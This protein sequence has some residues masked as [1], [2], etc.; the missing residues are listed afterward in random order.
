MT[1]S[2]TDSEYNENLRAE[3][4]AYE[5]S[6][7]DVM[8]AEYLKR[9][10]FVESALEDFIKNTSFLL[11]VLWPLLLIDPFLLL[12]GDDDFSCLIALSK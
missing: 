2:F 9:R 10:R 6:L 3:I 7:S 5:E 8:L 11:L 4:M 12:R 1:M